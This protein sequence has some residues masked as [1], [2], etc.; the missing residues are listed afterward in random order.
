MRQWSQREG[1]TLRKLFKSVYRMFPSFSKPSHIVVIVHGPDN[2]ISAACTYS[3]Q[4]TVESNWQLL[5]RDIETNPSLAQ[6]T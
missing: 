3:M 4:N 6:Q 1:I 5:C 2:G